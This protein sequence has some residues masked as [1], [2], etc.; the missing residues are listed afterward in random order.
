MANLRKALPPF[1]LPDGKYARHP[2]TRELAELLRVCAYQPFPAI[3]CK[4]HNL[5]QI[6][7]VKTGISFC[8]AQEDS[9][10][11]YNEA[12]KSGEPL[13]AMGAVSREMDYYWAT[14]HKGTY[15]GHPD[16]RTLSGGCYFCLQERA[17]RPI[18]PRQAALASG[19]E[20]Y[21]PTT[22]CN[23]CGEIAEKRV[24]NGE[25]RGCLGAR[26]VEPRIT[27][28][29]RQWPDMIIPREDAKTAGMKTYRTGKACKY[30]HAGW[31]WVSTRGCLTC[32]GRD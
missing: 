17:A 4:V 12:V 7:F 18:S 21:T 28:I 3:R 2:A 27:P 11:A 20:W 30:G 5:Q 16:K 10:N 29:H 6:I 26:D 32:Q 9:I 23:R 15:C 31:R 8:C 1:L 19:E 24:A 13:T 22:P 25:C 14:P